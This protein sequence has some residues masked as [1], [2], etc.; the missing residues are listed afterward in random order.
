MK[1]FIDENRD[2]FKNTG[3]NGIKVD[4]ENTQC[5]SFLLDNY[6]QDELDNMNENKIYELPEPIK[7]NSSKNNNLENNE[8]DIRG[9]N[10][11]DMLSNRFLAKGFIS[12]KKK[13]SMK[14]ILNMTN[15]KINNNQKN[16]INDETDEGIIEKKRVKLLEN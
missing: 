13:S 9:K 16:E 10:T 7:I 6:F 5:I 4:K 12:E 11:K 14:N 8:N 15:Y 2:K 3:K 1:A